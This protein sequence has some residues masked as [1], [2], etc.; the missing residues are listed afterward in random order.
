MHTVHKH[1]WGT[2]P[3]RHDDGKLIHALCFKLLLVTPLLL[4]WIKLEL[5]QS[6]CT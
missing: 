6:I 1:I 2:R 3:L 4:D 5:I